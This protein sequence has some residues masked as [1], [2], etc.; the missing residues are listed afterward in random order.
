MAIHSSARIA[1]TARVDERAEIGAD[2]EIGPFCIVEGEVSIGPRSQLESHVVVKRW[3]TLGTDNQISTGT[4][5]GT[6]PLDKNF[7]G[8]R[9]YLTIGNGN[10]IREHY[11]ISRGTEPESTTEIGDEN[12]IMTSGHIAHNC[13]IGSGNIICSCALVAGHVEIEDHVF[14]SGGVL[15]HQ[16]SKIGRLALISGNARVHQDTAPYFIYSDFKIRPRAVNVIGLQRA[17]FQD[18]EIRRLKRA[19]NFLFR[20]GL[21]I[22][23]ALEQIEREV[24]DEHTRHL[25]SFVRRSKRGICR[26]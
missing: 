15:V 12:Y 20:S 4:V 1:D 2:V 24:P 17:G 18:E 3:T 8:E 7:S 11:T 14:I 21:S 25:V 22:S 26:R 10:R 19:F 16:H 9:S 5:L 13:K 6:D 23:A